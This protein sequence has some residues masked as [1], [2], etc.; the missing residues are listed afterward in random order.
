MVHILH[1]LRN[2]GA[3]TSYVSSPHT[4]TPPDKK[5]D[6]AISQLDATVRGGRPS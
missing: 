1:H 6:G 3:D 2:I 4:K 5:P